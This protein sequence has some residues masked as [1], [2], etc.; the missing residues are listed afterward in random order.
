MKKS[1]KSLVTSSETKVAVLCIFLA[2]GFSS[3]IHNNP[4]DKITICHIPP[5]NPSNAHEITISRNALLTHLLHGDRMTCP[6][7]ST[8][9]AFPTE[10]H[11]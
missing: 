11:L 3:F 2:I 6:T 10:D 4:Q 9:G 8:D 7:D 1:I 5:G